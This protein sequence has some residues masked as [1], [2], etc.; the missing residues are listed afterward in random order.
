MKKFK[1]WLELREAMSP[2]EA[3]KQQNVPEAPIDDQQKALV[4][5]RLPALPGHKK[6]PAERFKPFKQRPG[7]KQI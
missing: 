6:H 5:K 7:I 2:Q 4:R 1:E 3:E